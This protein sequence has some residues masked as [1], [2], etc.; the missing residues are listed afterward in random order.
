MSLVFRN[1]L[2]PS[3]NQQVL[4]LRLAYLMPKLLIRNKVARLLANIIISLA[5]ILILVSTL[6]FG[7]ILLFQRTCKANIFG[8]FYCPAI[9]SLPPF[10]GFLV[11]A[12]I[13][14]LTF[15]PPLW[16]TWYLWIKKRGTKNK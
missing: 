14:L 9:E 13:V 6:F 1:A 15:G 4:R 3:E 11:Q 10:V 7:M 16:L 12:L 2:M 5:W 8:H